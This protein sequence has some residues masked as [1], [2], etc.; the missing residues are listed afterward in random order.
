M[1]QII[2]ECAFDAILFYAKMAEQLAASEGFIKDYCAAQLHTSHGL[3]CSTELPIRDFVN[4]WG[5]QRAALAELGDFRIDMA[6]YDSVSQQDAVDLRSLTEFKL[7]TDHRKIQ[8]DADRLRHICNVLRDNDRNSSVQYSV[9]GYVV[10]CPQYYQGIESSMRALDDLGRYFP[11]AYR[12]DAEI[13]ARYGPHPVS[14]GVGVAVID[15]DSIAD[16]RKLKADS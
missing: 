2:G 12:K 6:T 8:K 11:Y 1:E 13:N 3:R 15:V 4:R 14:F 10:V 9:R 16:F 7:W 5:F